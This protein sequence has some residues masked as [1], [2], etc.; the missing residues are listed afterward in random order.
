MTLF[1]WQKMVW[2]QPNLYICYTERV[3]TQKVPK[4]YLTKDLPTS[5][6]GAAYYSSS[7]RRKALR[8]IL[9]AG[10]KP[11]TWFPPGILVE[12]IEGNEIFHWTLTSY[13]SI[14]SISNEINF[15]IFENYFLTYEFFDTRNRYYLIQKI[16]RFYFRNFSKICSLFQKC[17]FSPFGATSSDEFEN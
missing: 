10:G 3:W 13:S 11:S 5:R 9:E 6:I 16:L 12:L 4:R 14:F 8:V 7:F 2:R 15:R 1:S 17:S